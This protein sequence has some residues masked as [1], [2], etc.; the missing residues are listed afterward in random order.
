MKTFTKV[1]SF[2]IIFLL[3]IICISLVNYSDRDDP[4]VIKIV[5]QFNFFRARYSPQ[6]VYLHTDKATYMAGETMWIKAYLMDAARL[7]PDTVSKEIYVEFLDINNQP[8][9]NLILKN[10]QG[11][12]NGSILL[13]DSLLEGNYQLRAYTNWMR[14]FD[15]DYFFSKTITIKNP[16]YENFI[17]RPKLK[18][19][20]RFNRILRRKDKE[21]IVTFFPEG[22]M[23]VAGLPCNVAFKAE[24]NFGNALNIKGVLVDNKGKQINLFQSVHEG[25]GNFRFTP[26]PGMI[27]HAKVTYEN[28]KTKNYP[29]PHALP[30]GIVM[31]IDP[32]NENDIKVYV[33]SNRPIS[34]NIASNEVIILGQSRGI[35]TYV[36]KGEVKDKPVVSVI[37]KKLFPSGIAQITVFNGRGEPICERLVFIDRQIE[38]NTNQVKLTPNIVGD[39]VIYN[40]KLKQSNGFPAKGNFSLT[41]V[42]SLPNAISQEK[43]NILTNLLL[44][45]D[46]K[47]RINNASYYFDKN[48]PDANKH[49]DLVMLTH[50]WRRF[51]W[52]EI[53]ANKFPNLKYSKAGGISIVG[54]IT[55]DLLGIPMRQ[56]KVVLSIQKTYNDKFETI[57]DSKGKFEFPLME[58]EDTIEVKI[59]AFKSGEG[60]RGQIILGDTLSPNITTTPLPFYYNE[61]YEKKKLSANSRREEIKRKKKVVENPGVE[62]LRGRIYSDPSNVLLVGKDASTYS[63]ILEYMKGKIPGVIITG[64]RVLIRGVNTFLGGTDPL[65]L[66]DGVPINPSSV[67]MLN[68]AD[69]ER[70]EILKGP[71]ASIYGSNAANG[72]IAFYSKHG[73]YIKRGVIEFGMLGYHKAREFYVPPYDSWTYKPSD[74]HVPKTIFWSPNI[75]TDME[76]EATIRFK[77]KFAVEKYTTVLEGL[78]S[79][80]GIICAKTQD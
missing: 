26:Q 50:G 19:L 48:N 47:G 77:K 80:G 40:I 39:S 3:L 65:F 64:D 22:G 33:Q 69:I 25:L 4:R 38:S 44:T 31:S 11:F 75:V 54:R 61:Q 56:S 8:V 42:E 1:R 76:G 36:S 7:L 15:S 59:E 12:S 10:R 35:I 5:N 6:K 28:G 30:K 72:V 67:S 52:Q 66:L 16:N 49:L 57:T 18:E 46:L 13:K 45:S 21:N 51:V 14:N 78:T 60:R 53:I 74:Y 71:E 20:R 58:Y 62:N 43:E 29:L 70:I 37:P 32:F 2:L 73:D 34:E 55:R 63:N 27:Y 17:T 68:T 9:N 23:L 41:M 24:T 79:S